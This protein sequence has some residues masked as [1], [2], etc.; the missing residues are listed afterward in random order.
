MSGEGSGDDGDGIQAVYLQ[1]SGV[2]SIDS[3]MQ[4]KQT[5]P[6]LSS[7]TACFHFFIQHTR[8]KLTP[9]LSYS[10]TAFQDELLICKWREGLDEI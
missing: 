7:V 5:V 2:P 8:S 1:T 4:W 6:T 3:Y 10:V 9:L